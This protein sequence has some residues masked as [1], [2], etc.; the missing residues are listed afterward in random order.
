[1]TRA[2]QTAAA[3]STLSKTWVLVVIY[4]R[5]LLRKPVYLAAIVLSFTV[6]MAAVVMTFA[7]REGLRATLD[8][9]SQPGWYFMINA[10][11]N[12][13]LMSQVT[14]A[15]ALNLEQLHDA[16]V[17]HVRGYSAELAML[18]RQ[19][20][21]GRDKELIVR[22][23]TDGAF[24]L[25][26][27]LS[28]ANYARIIEG[29]RFQPDKNEV[30][31]GASLRNHYPD[32]AVGHSILLKGQPWKI[33][34]VFTSGGSVRESEFWSDLVHLRTDYGLAPVYSV[35]AFGGPPASAARYNATLADL[36]K[37]TLTIRD[38]REHYAG[39]AQDLIDLVMY[40][41]LAFA[42]LVGIVAATG[43][44]A[45]IESLLMD[46]ADDLRVLALIGFGRERLIAHLALI[47]L[48]GFAGGVL[49]LF[50]CLLL[51]SGMTFTTYSQ[52]REL[53]FSISIN[54]EVISAS[55]AY[56]VLL[57]MAAAALVIPRLQRR[58][59]HE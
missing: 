22:G 3:T 58:A 23:V 5:Q 54:R 39:Q 14:R 57:G 51:F 55:L 32:F 4:L 8:A 50:I 28:G 33:V 42:V 46:N 25:V 7:V 59:R 18:T 53:A 47:G 1:M 19:K 36:E 40:F 15:Q 49:G 29:R 41:G 38:S 37:D 24:S 30:I 21:D 17:A 31:V 26:N 34:G 10:H 16:D 52:S 13:E 27:P 45:L 20:A 11:A 44:A 2:G 56:C 35:I 6:V 12:T 43:V 48:L 9:S